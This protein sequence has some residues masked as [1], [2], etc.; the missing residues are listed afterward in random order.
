M[1]KPA[2]LTR[3]NSNVTEA[4]CNLIIVNSTEATEII[5]QNARPLPK[6][7]VRAGYHPVN[8]FLCNTL[9]NR[10]QA[11]MTHIASSNHHIETTFAPWLISR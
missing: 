6:Q 9:K 3:V 4:N 10:S 2:G 8:K 7:N 11:Q 5:T 1:K